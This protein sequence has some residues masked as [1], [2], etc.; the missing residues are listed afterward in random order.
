MVLQSAPPSL[1]AH[2]TS[3]GS[4]MSEA[5]KKGAKDSL[6]DLAKEAIKQGAGFVARMALEH[7]PPHLK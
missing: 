4:A 5:V 1:K 6:G 3:L 7:L 2:E